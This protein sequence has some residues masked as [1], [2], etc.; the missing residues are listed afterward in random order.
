[1]AST[2]FTAHFSNSKPWRVQ[3][4]ESNPFSAQGASCTTVLP[5]VCL[6]PFGKTLAERIGDPFDFKTGDFAVLPRLPDAVAQ[7]PHSAGHLVLIDL[8]RV[9]D[10][11]DHLVFTQRIP[12]SV[13]V[14]GGVGNHEVGVKLRIEGAARIVRERRSANV[15]GDFGSSLNRG[16]LLTRGELL[17]FAEGDPRRTLMGRPEARVPAKHREE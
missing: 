13:P 14:A 3:H 16:V 5:T 11:P 10:R 17:Q 2:Y 12:F 6:P 15:P 7:L 1:M 9:A 8:A 4:S